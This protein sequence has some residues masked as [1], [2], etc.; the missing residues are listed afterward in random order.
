MAVANGQV[1][2]FHDDQLV[3]A[4]ADMGLLTAEL[5]RLGV[6]IGRIDPHKSLGLALLDGLTGLGRGVEALKRDPVVER[7]LTVMAAERAKLP[8]APA[9]TQLDLLLKGL[10]I[11]FARQYQDWLPT[12][13]KNHT[14]A[15]IAGSPH[16][17]GGGVGDPVP[18]LDKLQSRDRGPADGRGVRVGLLDTRI[19]PAPWLAGG[20]LALPR[21][22]VDPHS[23]LKAT[24]AHGTTVAS[25][26]LNRAP[27]AELYLVRTLD[28]Y[29]TADTW[30]AAKAIAEAADAGFDVVNLSFGE[31]FTDDGHPPIVLA[32]AAELL[33]ARSVVVASA[34]NHGNVSRM[35]PELVP[36]GLTENSPSYPAALPGVL[37]VGALDGDGRPAAFSPKRAPWISLMA[38]GVDVTVAYLEGDVLIEHKN[39]HDK[40]ISSRTERFTGWAKCSGTSF[41]AAEVTGE[42]AARTIPGR[43]SARQ[44]SDELRNP[45][46]VRPENEIWPHVMDG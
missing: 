22:L 21:D 32:T 43:V 28:D 5:T 27:A 18:T 29:S 40:I 4:I 44:V 6:E 39:I 35:D 1:E 10:R 15:Q 14:I 31:Y 2:A 23:E 24:Q 42:I 8:D 11:L 36:K 25:R 26:I 13:G 20:Y 17:G 19:F 3:V 37:A 46:K 33:S 41:S 7:E 34:G 45:G 30:T 38:P 12:L 9:W 16:I